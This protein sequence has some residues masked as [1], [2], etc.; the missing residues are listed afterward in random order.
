MLA[1][2]LLVGCGSGGPRPPAA[3]C[4][5][6]VGDGAVRLSVDQAR[7]AA[8]IAAVARRL[9]LPDHAVTIALATALQESGLRNLSYGDRDSLGVFQQRP[10][11]GWGTAAQVQRPEYAATAFFTR[12]RDV[13]GWPSLPVTVAAQAVQRSGFPEAYAQHEG[14]AR[15]LAQAYTGQVPAAVA[16]TALP[17]SGGLRSAQLQAAAARELG[18]QYLDRTPAA[19]L[20]LTA[21]WVVAHADAYGVSAVTAG[22]RRWT[23]ATGTWSADAAA[24]PGVGYA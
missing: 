10:S 1:A 24:Q 6:T 2:A 5:A 15:V 22:G 3:S 4:S 9:G 20:W 12:L 7:N 14:D 13:P 11:Q 19:D 23:A 18:R 21:S 16:C 17:T 8:T